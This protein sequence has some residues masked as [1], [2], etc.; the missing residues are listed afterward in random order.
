[1]DQEKTIKQ[2]S[3]EHAVP[4]VSGLMLT[5]FGVGFTARG[6][7]L[8]AAPT[9]PPRIVSCTVSGVDAVETAQLAR[10]QPLR[11]ELVRLESLA[12]ERTIPSYDQETYRE[13]ADRIRKDIEAAQATYRAA[14]ENLRAKCE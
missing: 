12:S 9:E 3:Q 6:S 1:M 7:F 13:S 5:A 14:I 4:Y 2:R 10:I 8:P 11:D